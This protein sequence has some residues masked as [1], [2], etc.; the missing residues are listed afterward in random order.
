MKNWIEWKC[1]L[2]NNLVVKIVDFSFYFDPISAELA[3]LIQINSTRGFFSCVQVY[4]TFFPDWKEANFVLI[5]CPD[6]NSP[7]PESDSIR[8]FLYGMSLPQ[9]GIKIADLGNLKP[10]NS[11]RSRLEALSFI[12]ES[13]LK[14]EKQVIL[15]GGRQEISIGQYWA[16]ENLEEEI[17][18]ATIDN[19]LNINDTGNEFNPLGCNHQIFIHSPN[20]LFHFVN[21]GTQN[22]YVSEEERHLIQQLHFESVRLGQ[23][24]PS[25]QLAEPYLRMAQMIVFDLSAIR[26]ADAP[27]TMLGGPAGFTTEEA[28]SLARYAGM[29]LTAKT[30]SVT[31]LHL[32]TDREGQTAHLAALLVWYYIEGV[33]NRLSDFPNSNRS[34]V[35]RYRVTL[36]DEITKEITFYKS[37]RTNRWWMEVPFPEAL[38]NPDGRHLLV[39]CSYE[40][41]LTAQNG[42]LPDRWLLMHAKNY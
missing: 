22:H 32:L 21:L 26:L 28:C 10:T 15:L 13:L 25:I 36:E 33:C 30:F 29:G 24:R 40:D 1:L 37:Y 14:A 2:Y 23:L 3:N 35:R 6:P 5:G 20:Y 39:A 11:T 18:V 38:H 42:D 31:E 17:T 4:H 8:Q 9:K 12:L 41:Y 19:R 7:I 16:F 27:G 34:N